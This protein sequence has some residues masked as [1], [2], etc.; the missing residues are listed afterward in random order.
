M[1]GILFE[2]KRK[3]PKKRI[4]YEEEEDESNSENDEIDGESR[5]RANEKMEKTIEKKRIKKP[6]RKGISKTI[7]M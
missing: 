4:I 5:R 6:S 1:F 3:I 2:K 7:K